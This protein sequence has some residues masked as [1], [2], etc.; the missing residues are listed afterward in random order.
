[1]DDRL[2]QALID[3]AH[4]A[5]VAHDLVALYLVGSRARSDFH[6]ESD[7]DLAILPRSPGVDVLELTAAVTE[8]LQPHVGGRRLDVIV[9]DLR[10]LLFLASLL[11]DAVVV[12]CV[13]EPARV[14]FEV[15][16]M[17]RTLDFEQHAGP[18]RR[19]LLAQTAQGE[20]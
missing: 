17:S 11:R 18:L 3:P 6:E 14:A 10:Q 16:A 7:I 9:L 5:L 8:L 19:E 2:R 1:M 4:A 15:Q 13:D 20:R 12:A